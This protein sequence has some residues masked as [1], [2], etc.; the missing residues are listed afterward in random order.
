MSI[1]T[2]S[3]DHRHLEQEGKPFFWL[4]DTIWSAF[5]NITLEDW[6]YYL[7]RRRTNMSTENRAKSVP[8]R[9]A[10]SRRTV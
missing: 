8:F 3:A 4:A 6:A 10:E 7:K 5:T 2:I 1:L 9:Y